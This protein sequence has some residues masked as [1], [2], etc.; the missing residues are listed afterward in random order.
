MY[1]YLLILA[2]STI[3]IK[4]KQP[5]F[6]TILQ[7]INHAY[8]VK[9]MLRTHL[10]RSV[11]TSNFVKIHFILA[12][13]SSPVL[14]VEKYLLQPAVKLRDSACLSTCTKR[15]TVFE[16]RSSNTPRQGFNPLQD[17]NTFS[18]FLAGHGNLINFLTVFST[19]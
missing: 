14:E 6:K 16:T 17:V 18:S 3:R 12:Y 11:E 2:N 19:F 7:R 1:M 10:R 5:I 4:Y 13:H 8:S 9:N 15:G